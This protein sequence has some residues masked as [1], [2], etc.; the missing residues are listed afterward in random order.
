MEKLKVTFVEGTGATYCVK[1]KR[2]TLM[3][4][5]GPSIKNI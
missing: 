4:F 2:K 3:T 1:E 5:K